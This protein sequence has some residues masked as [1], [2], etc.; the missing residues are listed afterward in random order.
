V[1][2]G[3]QYKKKTT[4]GWDLQVEWRDGSTSWLPLKQLKESNPVEVA[5][6]AK[7][8]QLD[9]EPAF[10]WWVSMVLRRKKRLIKTVQ[11]RHKRAG[12]KFGI[13]L[14]RSIA[15]AREL[16]RQNGNTLWMDALRK[17]MNGVMVAFEPQPEGTTH[18]PGYKQIPGFIVWDVKMDFTRKARFVAGGHKTEPPKALIYSS[19][20]SRDSV[21]LALLIA[22][23]ND[24]EIRLTDIKNAYLNAPITERYYVI[25]GDEFGPEYKGRCMKIVRALYGLKSA[26]AAFRAHLATIL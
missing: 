12:Y 25:A 8:N 2:N 22:G 18:V 19:V 6:Y 23:L 4:A 24:L 9:A 14:P 13:R 20:V 21:R 15:E 7:A 16:D 5:E 1:R 17:E 10:D 26:G 3:K 11:T